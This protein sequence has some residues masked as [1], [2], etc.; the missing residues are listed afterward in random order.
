MTEAYG[1]AV[2]APFWAAA[3]Q[4]LLLQR[5][6]SCGAHQFY[7]RPFC[8]ACDHDGLSWTPASG[9]GVIY[10]RTE[11]RVKV[12]PELVPPYTVAVVALAEGP[13]MTTLVV[14]D[15]GE[16]GPTC[17]IGDAVEVAWM[18][19]TDAPPLPVFRRSA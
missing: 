4:E 17:E 19:R 7:P 14:G 3:G 11:V 5:C 18:P 10:S 15:D 12:R 6:D 13:R 2:T 8:L 1:D 9:T 16:P